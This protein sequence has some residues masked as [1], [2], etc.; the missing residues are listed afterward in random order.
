MFTSL[1]LYYIS[2][3]MDKICEIA[4][5]NVNNLRVFNICFSSLNVHILKYAK[6][7]FI[8][9]LPSGQVK[10]STRI[11]ILLCR[12]VTVASHSCC[13]TRDQLHCVYT[14]CCDVYSLWLTQGSLNISSTKK[15]QVAYEAIYF[16]KPPFIC[17]FHGWVLIIVVRQ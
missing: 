8:A 14:H 6:L 16:F 15:T 17:V 12:T 9:S 10:N 4:F 13:D 2:G 11:I 1:I 3:F 5:H 7:I